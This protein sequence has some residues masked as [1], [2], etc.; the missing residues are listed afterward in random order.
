MACEIATL[1]YLRAKTNVPIPQVYAYSTSSRNPIGY[2]YMLEE[3]MPGI[4]LSKRR[5]KLSSAQLSTVIRQLAV[6]QA[7]LFHRCFSA[8]EGLQKT[9][10]GDFAPSTMAAIQ[11][12][13]Y[14]RVRDPIY[15][16]LFDSTNSWM[17][18]LLQLMRNETQRLY[19]EDMAAS[20]SDSESDEEDE[21]S[22]YEP[23]LN[24][25]V[26][27]LQHLPEVLE[28]LSLNAVGD[29]H[30]TGTVLYHPDLSTHN[31]LIDPR[32]AR[33]TAI[34][35]WENVSAVPLWA[36]CE[37]P[38]V[39][40]PYAKPRHEKPN[41]EDYAD[42][43]QDKYMQR[44][45]ES[46]FDNEGKEPQF[47]K[48][49][50]EWQ[51]TQLQ[52]VFLE[53]MR[54]ICPEWV[55]MYRKSEALR[56]F[57]NVMMLVDNI[58]EAERV[59]EFIDRLESGERRSFVKVRFE[60]EAIHI[61]DLVGEGV[62]E[63]AADKG[64]HDQQDRPPAMLPSLQGADGSEQ[65]TKT[66]TLADVRGVSATVAGLLLAVWQRFMRIL[67]GNDEGHVDR[68]AQSSK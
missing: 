49:E 44:T 56:D 51:Q 42:M 57:A 61:A 23:V 12:L 10:D 68:R 45:K 8:I 14:Q 1:E 25:I 55:E 13:W 4:L 29:V 30:A 7:Q 18:T 34:I 21:G 48:H 50:F 31:I 24:N 43:D 3:F 58:W 64:G 26:Y 36:G 11:F 6:Y 22:D 52:A 65:N 5:N 27:L 40:A 54:Q 37:L 53:E 39:L 62:E 20:Q 28:K 66:G 38:V 9:A 17:R 2:E 32:T 41:R 19:D 59:K 35:D 46:G 67:G 33:I 63:Q 47:W 60:R 15:K 16:G